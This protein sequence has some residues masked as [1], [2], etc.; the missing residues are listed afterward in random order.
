MPFATLVYRRF[1]LV[2][3]SALLLLQGCDRFVHHAPP[4]YVYVWIR[5]GY[6][7]NRVSVINHRTADVYN[8]ERLQVLQHGQRFLKVKTPKGAVGWIEEHEVIDQQIYDAFV[9]MRNDHTSDP[10]VATGLMMEGYWMRDAPGRQSNRFYWIPKNAKVEMLTRASVPRNQVM[11]PL[12]TQG[13]DAAATHVRLEDFWLARDSAGDVGWIRAATIATDVP[14]ALLDLTVGRHIVGVYVLAT[15]HDPEA[16]TPDHE[17]P[18]YLTLLSPWKSGL[19]WDFD[20]AEVFTWNAKRHRYETAWRHVGFFGYLPV[21]VS[22]R[23]F[24]GRE[25][26][27]FSFREAV[28]EPAGIDPQ[29]G[30]LLHG[31]TETKYYRMQGHVIRPVAGHPVAHKDGTKRQYR[32]PGRALR[33]R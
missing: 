18:E 24:E 14:T 30:L 2:A 20:E 4:E 31:A 10:I 7:I 16:T 15:E 17:V 29:T 13:E 1:L 26:P 6:L 33:R 32:K 27:F 22:H 8:G 21:A 28:G 25:E 5:N 23:E 11:H 9:R 12:P 3:L 19:P